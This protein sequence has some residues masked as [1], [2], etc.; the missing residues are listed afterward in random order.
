MSEFSP[1]GHRLLIQSNCGAGETCSHP[2]LSDFSP[3]KPCSAR[4]PMNDLVMFYRYT[5]PFANEQGMQGH[6]V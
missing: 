5:I 4:V 1:N 6:D 2:E 3:E